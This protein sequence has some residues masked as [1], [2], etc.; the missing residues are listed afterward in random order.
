MEKG[1]EFRQWNVSSQYRWRYVMTVGRE[2]ARCTVDVV[3]VQV[4][5]WCEWGTVKGGDFILCYGKWISTCRDCFLQLWSFDF[6]SP[7]FCWP[8][9][10]VGC[11]GL[12]FQ[13]S[14][15]LLRNWDL[16]L[17]QVRFITAYNINIFWVIVKVLISAKTTLSYL[18]LTRARKL[19]LKFLRDSKKTI[20]RCRTEK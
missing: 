8:D 12:M 17:A 20:L 10:S 5:R 3:S 16:Q 15:T 2:L 1:R 19:T 7:W 11:V 6:F 18:L 4:V 14:N 13:L 9:V